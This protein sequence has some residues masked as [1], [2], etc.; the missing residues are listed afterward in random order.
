MDIKIIPY[1]IF[2]WLQDNLNTFVKRFHLVETILPFWCVSNAFN[3]IYVVL[4]FKVN[5]FTSMI[6]SLFSSISLYWTV[7]NP[8][9]LWSFWLKSL[10]KETVKFKKMTCMG[11]ATNP[12]A[13]RVVHVL[14]EY[15]CRIPIKYIDMPHQFLSQNSF[16]VSSRD[17][18][19]T[20]PFIFD[21]NS[22]K[23]VNV[24]RW[25]LFSEWNS[26]LKQ[27]SLLLARDSWL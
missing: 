11:Y 27:K 14:S 25:F 4:I 23:Y 24:I 9:N 15:R 6:S 17:C 13:F 5:T 8:N 16:L 10:L 19:R 12:F 2:Q 26:F 20:F 22:A 3:E 7:R 21:S 1:D 18:F